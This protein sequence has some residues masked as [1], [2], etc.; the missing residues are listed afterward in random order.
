MLATD[1][2]LLCTQNH[3]ILWVGS[4]LQGSWSPSLRWIAH[5][6]IKPTTLAL[7]AL[8]FNQLRSSQCQSKQTFLSEKILNVN[9]IAVSHCD[10]W[11]YT[12]PFLNIYH[13]SIL[14]YSFLFAFNFIW[15]SVDT[16]LEV[17][18]PTE[19]AVFPAPAWLLFLSFTFKG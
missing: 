10:V 12:K 3:R 7:L 18:C 11:Y 1:Q 5:T 16:E 4:D 8:C 6:G 14:D 2:C 17:T 13:A 19:K 15:M 9:R